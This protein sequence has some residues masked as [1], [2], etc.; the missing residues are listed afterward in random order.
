MRQTT[1]LSLKRYRRHAAAVGDPAGHD[2]SAARSAA[3]LTIE[4]KEGHSFGGDAVEVGC[5]NATAFAAAVDS[6]ITPAYVIT[7]YE[8][9]IWLASTSL[10]GVLLL[11][12]PT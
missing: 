4:G 10:H 8:D 9:D 1:T 3:W 2:R 6:Q 12:A 11:F 5:R 7:D